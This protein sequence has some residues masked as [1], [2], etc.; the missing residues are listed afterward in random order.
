M[1]TLI[2]S[3]AIVLLLFTSCNKTP[4]PFDVS[5]HHI[6]LLTDSTHVKDLKSIFADD[7]ITEVL[8]NGF[9]GISKSIEVFDKTGNKLLILNPEYKSDTTAVVKSVQIID[10]RYKTDKNITTASTFK[11]I[12]DNYKISRI[13]NLI[14][15]I[16][17]SVNE[18]NASFTIDKNELPAN[19]RFDMDLEIEATHIPDHAKI[20]YFFINW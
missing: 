14:N 2:L 8:N 15:S 12:S 19:V 9:Y 4:N 6:G 1:K 3:I 10:S 16:V 18:I 20:K 17:V 11:D 13:D 5:K 7:S